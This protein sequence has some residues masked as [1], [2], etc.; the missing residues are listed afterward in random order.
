MKVISFKA[1]AIVGVICSLAAVVFLFSQL[2]QVNGMHFTRISAKS[3]QPELNLKIENRKKMRELLIQLGLDSGW[4][5][6]EIVL[7]DSP[8]PRAKIFWKDGDSSID[9]ISANILQNDF[10]V[11]FHIYI[12]PTLEKGLT[13]Q[14]RSDLIVEQLISVNC[15]DII[16]GRRPKAGQ[17]F[18][19]KTQ[20]IEHFYPGLIG[21]ALVSVERK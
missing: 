11:S 17:S 14:R 12:S 8:Q 9:A 6:V 15:E 1:T 10:L 4:R 20:C 16:K 5:P 21:A 2:A 13:D 19:S 7:V 3:L 18:S